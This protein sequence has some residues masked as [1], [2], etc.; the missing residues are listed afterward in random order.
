[1]VTSNI[2][3]AIVSIKRLSLFLNAEELQMYRT[4]IETPVL[5]LGD[6]VGILVSRS[7]SAASSHLPQV[8]SIKNANFSWSKANAEATLE[9]ITLS[10]KKGE[11][12]GLFG[13]VGAGKVQSNIK[14]GFISLPDQSPLFSQVYFPLSW[15]T[16]IAKRGKL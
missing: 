7:K 6:E 5:R 15:A 3:E 4:M 2:V 9:G 8:L 13:R 10:V 11:L 16:F 12:L 1:M 14:T